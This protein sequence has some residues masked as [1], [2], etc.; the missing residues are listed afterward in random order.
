MFRQVLS[1]VS[2]NSI[3]IAGD[4]N[5]Q[6]SDW[7]ASKNNCAGISLNDYLIQ[8][9]F[10][11]LNDGNSTR[12]SANVNHISCPDI[13]LIKSKSY[14]FTWNVGDDPIG[15]NHLPIEIN[16]YVKNSLIHRGK[17]GSNR[18]RL[19][20][21]YLDKK[22]INLLVTQHMSQFLFESEAIL[23][24]DKWYNTVIECSFLTESSITNHNGIYKKLD[25]NLYVDVYNN[26]I[27]KK[28]QVKNSS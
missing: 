27:S 11:I 4:L 19:F 2:F 25:S 8:S 9:Q 28:T 23:F 22:L 14:N 1:V 15:S 21:N 3:V 16:V 13:T 17:S 20:L 10:V 12:I 18:P 6:F 5:A 26:T 24:Y 7:G